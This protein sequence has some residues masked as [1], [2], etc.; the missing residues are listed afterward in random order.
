MS[1][2]TN[3]VQIANKI[4]FYFVVT[5]VPV[6]I[7]TNFI[8]ML[9]FTRKSLNATNMGFFNLLISISNIVTLVFYLFFMESNRVFNYDLSI[10]SDFG[11]KLMM[12]LRR[13][14]REMAPI[15]ETVM[16]LERFMTV[17]YPKRFTVFQKRSFLSALILIIFTCFV[18]ISFENLFYYL[19]ISNNTRSCTGT[20]LIVTSSDLISATLR[21]FTPFAVMFTLNVLMLRRII[22]R[23]IIRSSSKSRREYQFTISVV[24]MN[25]LFLALNLPV[26]IGYILKAIYSD[27]RTYTAQM[28]EFYWRLAYL[29]ATCHYILTNVTNFVFNRLFREELFKIFSQP[30]RESQLNIVWSLVASSGILTNLG[31]VEK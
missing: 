1:N 28:V 23:K 26:S 14:I 30:R 22:S 31:N 19:E 8:S 18:I 2:S 4:D 12:L 5:L 24:S 11:C 20:Q 7:A 9:I 21:T 3:L 10:V 29:V 6:G 15:V 13:V 17:Y 25:A 16:T 27:S